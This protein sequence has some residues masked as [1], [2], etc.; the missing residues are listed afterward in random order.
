MSE[1]KAPP[2]NRPSPLGPERG[3]GRVGLLNFVIIIL[4][5]GFENNEK[6]L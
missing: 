1:L 5:F 2:T 6:Y 4:V 3:M